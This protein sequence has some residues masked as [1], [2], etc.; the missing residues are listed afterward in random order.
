MISK[1]DCLDKLEKFSKYEENWNGYGAAPFDKELINKCRLILDNL[2]V[3]PMVFPTAN[4]SIQFEY[5]SRNVYFEIEVCHNKYYLFCEVDGKCSNAELNSMSQAIDWWNVLAL[6][7]R[8]RELNEN[9]Q[10]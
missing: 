6:M 7:V 9:L 1:Q 4:D 3:Y 8:E 10:M 5:K 2:I